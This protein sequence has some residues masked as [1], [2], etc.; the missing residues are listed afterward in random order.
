MAQNWGFWGFDKNLIH[1]YILFSLNL[2][3]LIIMRKPCLGKIWFLRN[4]PKTTR[5]I[6][7]QYLQ[8]LQPVEVWSRFF[9]CDKTSIEAKNLLHHDIKKLW[10]G[11][12]GMPKIKTKSESVLHLKNELNYKIGFSH[13][14]RGSIEITN[15]LHHFNWVWL[16]M[17]KVIQNNKL[18]LF[19]K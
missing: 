18:A 2:E 14:G 7:I 12:L 16:R 8:Y 11:M 10:S 9:V 13:M 19:Q 6:R 1:S 15:L 17:P 5:P 3:V 4:Y